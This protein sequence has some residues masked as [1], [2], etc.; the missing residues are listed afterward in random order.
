MASAPI[1]LIHFLGFGL[2]MTTLVA[3]FLLE[4]QFRSAKE[5]PARLVVLRSL[6]S[7]GILSPI[8]MLVILLS[9]IGN[10]NARGWGIFTQGWLT[11]KIMFFALLVISGVLFAVQSRKR[12][13]LVSAI[14]KAPATPEQQKS[15]KSYH[16][17][18]I[19]FYVVL[20]V[21]LLAIL[22]L[23]IWRP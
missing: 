22:Y 6:R 20:T 2:L 19:L 23:S 5:A 9:G 21:I 4:L 1:L 8:A 10:M 17:Q 13:N 16:G 15:L 11:A 12:S 7:I 3:G 18:I 14:A